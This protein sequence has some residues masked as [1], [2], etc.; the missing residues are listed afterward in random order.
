[1]DKKGQLGDA[2]GAVTSLFTV[3]TFF[4][5]VYTIDLQRQQLVYQKKDFKLQLKELQETREELKKQSIAQQK[6]E[7][8]LREQ[9]EKQVLSTLLNSYTS[10]FN[11]LL[12]KANAEFA[13]MNGVYQFADITTELTTLKEKINALEAKLEAQT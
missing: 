5:F 6:S 8:A 10:R 4:Y 7:E 2:F 1:M 9:I 12:N 3:L 11:T 13:F